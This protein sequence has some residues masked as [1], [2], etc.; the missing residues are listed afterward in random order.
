MPDVAVYSKKLDGAEAIQTF[1][2]PL[3]VRRKLPPP[4]T[5]G[6]PEAL[7]RARR[8]DG[9]CLSSSHQ[10]VQYVSLD[11]DLLLLRDIRFS[12]VPT[13]FLV[14]QLYMDAT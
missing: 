10:L 13:L 11:P 9:S 4:G 12:G 3:H 7:A 14:E 6:V 1:S 2:F 8:E 5:A